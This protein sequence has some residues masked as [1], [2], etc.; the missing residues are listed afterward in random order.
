[1]IYFSK[2]SRSFNSVFII[3][4]KSL[5][6]HAKNDIYPDFSIFWILFSITIFGVKFFFF[7]IDNL[8]VRKN[9][10]SMIGTIPILNIRKKKKKL[11]KLD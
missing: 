10:P 11:K 2:K 4:Q 1:M 8:W 6:F 3:V 5:N 7:S 9:N